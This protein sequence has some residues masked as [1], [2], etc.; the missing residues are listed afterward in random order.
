LIEVPARARVRK[1][2]AQ[3]LARALGPRELNVLPAGQTYSFYRAA[4]PACAFVIM[5]G[6]LAAYQFLVVPHF[7]PYTD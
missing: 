1:W 2:V 4:A 3:Q 6:L 5:L 7:S